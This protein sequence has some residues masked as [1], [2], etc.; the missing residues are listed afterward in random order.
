MVRSGG[1]KLLK[2]IR[3]LDS[4]RYIINS[5][6]PILSVMDQLQGTMGEA[7]AGDINTAMTDLGAMMKSVMNLEIVTTATAESFAVVDIAGYN[8]AD[9]RYI[10][11]KE[12]FPNRVIC[13]SETFSRDIANNWKL[14]KENVHII[15]DFT[16]TG[17]DYLGEA[18]IGKAEYDKNSAGSFMGNYPW[19]IAYCGDIDI[20]GNRRPVSYYREIV[21]GLY[22]QPY[23]AVQ[24]PEY[25][26]EE[27]IKTPWSWSDSISSWTWLGFE[28]K[29]IRVEVYSDAEEVE[30]LLNGKS[31]GRALV[32]E[33]KEFIAIFDIVYEPGELKAIAYVDGQEIGMITLQ[34]AGKGLDLRMDSDRD[35]LQATGEDLAYVTISFEDE[36]GVLQTSKDRKVSVNIEGAGVLQGFGSANPRST[37]NF[38]DTETTTFDGRALAVI[39]SKGEVGNIIVTA[40][41]EGCIPKTIRMQVR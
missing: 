20:I 33:E 21:F 24:R 39:R 14:V 22:K 4:T 7:M 17:W 3:S 36:V 38:L 19:K 32:G 25:Y 1:E 31:L 15:G 11:D 9:T 30:L 41:A 18:G 37:E 12:L 29:P 8:Y 16:W 27:S 6:N 10:T 35:V 34:T 26:Y 2:K 28:K 23:I 40:S 13:G 5:I